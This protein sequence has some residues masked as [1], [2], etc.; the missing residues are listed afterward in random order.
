MPTN[1][2]DERIARSYEATWP[3]LFEPATVDPVVDFLAGLAGSGAALELGHRDRPDRH[4]AAP[5][6]RPRARDRAVAGHGR[7]APDQAG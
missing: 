6:G 1:Y 7:G 3:E 5:A 2:F 4:P